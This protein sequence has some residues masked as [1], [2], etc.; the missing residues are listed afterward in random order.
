M[1]DFVKQHIV[2]ELFSSAEVHKSA[3]NGYPKLKAL[4]LHID[5]TKS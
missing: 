4:V 1:V 5:Y 3:F 2:I